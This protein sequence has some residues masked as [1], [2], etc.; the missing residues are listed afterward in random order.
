MAGRVA[1]LA[2]GVACAKTPDAGPGASTDRGAPPQTAAT[3]SA[4][5]EARATASSGSLAGT[6]WRAEGAAAAAG[7][8]VPALT[9]DSAQHVSGTT[10]CNRVSGAIAL[11]GSSLRFGPLMSSRRGCPGPVM[12][13][14]SR[15]LR[16]LEDC[17]TWRRAS[18]G[19]GASASG[20][21][22]ELLDASGAVVLR[23]E[24]LPP[25]DNTRQ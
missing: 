5:A 9:F 18:S 22:L 1:L 23:L 24:P 4:S 7:S 11:D 3:T 10:G 14:E 13:Q 2:L 20:E 8:T 6:S 19:T 12:E 21:T 16:A 15:F 17:R 25:G